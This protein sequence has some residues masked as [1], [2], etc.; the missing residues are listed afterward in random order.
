VTSTSDDIVTPRDSGTPRREAMRAMGF[1]G[2]ALLAV[3]GRS[4]A[5][6]PPGKDR[7]LSADKKRKRKRKHKKCNCPPIG[8]TFAL[9]DP[10][11]VAADTQKTEQAVCPDGFLALSGGLQGAE[12]VTVPC[13][14][15][16][17][18]VTADGTAWVVNVYC[19]EATNTNLVVGALCFSTSSFQPQ[20]PLRGRNWFQAD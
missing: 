17:S 20:N 10:F 6:Q 2:A 5:A 3:V 9:S 15:S 13:M 11:S 16:E 19:T 1:T 4:A 14:V 7:S 8:L 18:H 12:E